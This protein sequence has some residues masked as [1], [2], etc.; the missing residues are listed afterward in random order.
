M[1]PCF[2]TYLCARVWEAQKQ[3]EGSNIDLVFGELQRISQCLVALA[4]RLSD[5]WSG[6]GKVS[7]VTFLL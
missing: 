4:L 7:C 3:M 6:L 2:H 5:D 1:R